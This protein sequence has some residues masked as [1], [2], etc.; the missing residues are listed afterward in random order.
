MHSEPHDHNDSS[1]SSFFTGAVVG[2]ILALTFGTEDGRKFAKNLVKT[3]KVLGEELN[4][5][6]GNL[7]ETTKELR[8]Q[9]QEHLDTL[10]DSVRQI[11]TTVQNTGQQVINRLHRDLSDGSFFTRDGKPLS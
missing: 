9:T 8:Q 6:A 7:P 3:V 10:A 5:Q 1:L 11:N 2:G 4:K